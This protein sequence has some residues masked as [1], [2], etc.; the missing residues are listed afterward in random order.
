MKKYSLFKSW[1]NETRTQY[2]YIHTSVLYIRLQN[3]LTAFEN[4]YFKLLKC[5]IKLHIFY[6]FKTKIINKFWRRLKALQLSAVTAAFCQISA[7]LI[8]FN[9]RT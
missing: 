1:L 7:V 6:V 3:Y 5:L 9:G 8:E 4:I 2:Y